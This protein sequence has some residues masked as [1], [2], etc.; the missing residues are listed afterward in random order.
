M[1][2]LASAMVATR[3]DP[4]EHLKFQL[5]GPMGCRPTMSWTDHFFVVLSVYVA[6]YS[7]IIV[8]YSK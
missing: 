5:H 2:R 7:K 3:K 4:R 6:L 8:K 1:V